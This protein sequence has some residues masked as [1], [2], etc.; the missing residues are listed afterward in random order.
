MFCT[1]SFF[2]VLKGNEIEEAEN[3]VSRNEHLRSVKT[4]PFEVAINFTTFK[5]GPTVDG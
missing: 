3:S 4:F 5:L 1:C 2:L